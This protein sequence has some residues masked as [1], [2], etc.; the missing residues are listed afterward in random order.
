MNSFL[1]ITMLICLFST[2]TVYASS[3]GNGLP[4]GTNGKPGMPG[5]GGGTDPSSDGKFYTPEGIQC[6]PGAEDARKVPNH[7]GQKAHDGTV[8]KI[9]TVA[10]F[11]MRCI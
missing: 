4:G 3:G 2:G 7:P 10:K 9:G 11:A 6:N 5:C 8:A 1:K